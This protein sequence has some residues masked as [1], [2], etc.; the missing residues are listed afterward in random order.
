MTSGAAAGREPA[1]ELAAATAPDIVLMDITMPGIGGIEATRQITTANPL[2]A[3]LMLTMLDD[4]PSVLAAIRAGARGYLVK[5]A[6]DDGALRAIGR[7]PA[8]RS[9]S[10]L[11]SPQRSCASSG[12]H[13]PVPEPGPSR[14]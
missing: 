14:T 6:G 7:W 8:A 9:S 11:R 1:G 2:V 13:R 5:G 12:L 4:G 3:V 10:V